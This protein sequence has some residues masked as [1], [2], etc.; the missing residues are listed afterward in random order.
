[1]G[2][3]DLSH[4]VGT[5][6]ILLDHFLE[7]SDLTFDS[8]EALE[9]AGLDFGIDIVSLSAPDVLAASAGQ[10]VHRNLRNRSELVTTLTE[11]K[12]IAALAITGLS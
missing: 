5:V 3:G 8:T 2:R 7:A 6:A 12:A 11:L 1:M 4:H 9:V 10:L